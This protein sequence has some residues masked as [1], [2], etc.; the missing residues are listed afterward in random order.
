MPLAPVPNLERE[1]DALYAL[2]TEEFTRARN[3]LAARLRKAHQ[4]EAAAE[5]KGLKRPTVVAGIANR[6]ARERQAQVAQ[7]LEA[8]ERLRGVQQ[9]ALSG[10]ARADEVADASAEEREALHVLLGAARELVG[11][12][13]TAQLLD[14]LSQTLR[15]AAVNDAG[16]VLLQRGRLSEELEPVGFGPLEAVLLR[17]ARRADEVAKAAR[18]RVAAL[19]TE[20][21]RLAQEARAA[22][23]AADEAARA[24]EM[25]RGEAESRRAEAERAA[26]EL[27]EAEATLRDRR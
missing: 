11:P 10:K 15:A 14:R 17:P 24:A 6:L 4:A 20:S 16:R 27:A 9:R 25:L 19:R 3:D 1:L 23:R 22:E 5:V 21:R 26:T 12:R 2:P 18:E 13:A 7:L 8:G